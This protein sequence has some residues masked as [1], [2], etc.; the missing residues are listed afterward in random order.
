MS[1]KSIYLRLETR[2]ASTS[3]SDILCRWRYGRALLEAKAGRKQLPHG[4]IESL[5]S[6]AAGAGLKV[7]EREIQR[8]IKCAEVYGSEAEVRRASDGL[9]SWTA[10]HEAGFPSV[11]M[12]EPDALDA[13]GISTKAPD[14]FEQLSLIPGLA[15][16]LKVHGRVV[17]LDEATVADVEAY[18]DMY[19]QIHDNYGK[20]LALIQVA[21]E[22]MREG[23]GGDDTANAVQSWKRAI[24]D[25]GTS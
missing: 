1:K 9:G 25:G 16:T 6:D 3:A 13:A 20:R 14:E 5:I 23:S 24:D 8:R 18:R 4:M 7:S 12:D 2:I 11:Q 15:P 21:L 19:Q 22:A 17:P 10:L